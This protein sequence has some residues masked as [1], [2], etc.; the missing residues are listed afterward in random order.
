MIELAAAIIVEG[1]SAV[2]GKREDLA[3]GAITRKPLCIDSPELPIGVLEDPYG[4]RPWPVQ[5]EMI[6]LAAAIIV[7]GEDAIGGIRQVIAAD[8]IAW[9]P[10]CIDSSELPI[11]VL[12][13]PDRAFARPIQRQMIELAAAI[14]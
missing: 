5:C 13:D 2:C 7:K 14:V 9:S 8:A 10:L 6:E 3:A 4:A 12:E 1:E 11:G